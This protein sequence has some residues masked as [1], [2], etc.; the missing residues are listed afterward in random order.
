MHH[1]GVP[2]SYHREYGNA[3]VW[4]AALVVDASGIIRF[5]EVSQT[6]AD[7]PDSKKLLGE[8]RRVIDS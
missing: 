6:V 8:L 4:P 1:D 3:T 5:S 7:R 2:G